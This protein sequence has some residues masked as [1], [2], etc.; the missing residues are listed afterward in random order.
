MDDPRAID[1][2]ALAP[3][4]LSR[5]KV[6]L[7]IGATGLAAALVTQNGGAV[8][9]QA[10]TTEPDS[11]LPEG[12]SLT[13]LSSVPIRDLPTEPFQIVM[14]RITLEPGAIIPN[15]ALPYPSATYVEAGEN[16]IC[17][18]G[19]GGRFITD[20][21]GKLVDSGGHEMAFPLGTWCYTTP[22][23]M[24]GVRNDGPDQA[25]FLGVELVPME[26]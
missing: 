8:Y 4:G 23:A 7:G 24:D 9:A 14:Y 18:S 2:R 25:A 20:A 3:D 17:P 11:G 5:R 15:S 19:G 21:E 12:V 16:V 1:Q 22:D 13:S 26:S 6:L 10:G